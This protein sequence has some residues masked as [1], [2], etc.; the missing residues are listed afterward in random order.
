MSNVAKE[1]EATVDDLA[2]RNV[3]STGPLSLSPPLAACQWFDEGLIFVVKT[4]TPVMPPMG[5]V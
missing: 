4:R 5:L 3:D 1:A 2:D